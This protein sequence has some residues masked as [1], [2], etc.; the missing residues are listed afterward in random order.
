[1]EKAGRRKPQPQ[2]RR[3][4]LLQEALKG[5]DETALYTSHTPCNLYEK[6]EES[7]HGHN[8]GDGFKMQEGTAGEANKK[9]Q[10]LQSLHCS[11]SEVQTPN[12][13]DGCQQLVERC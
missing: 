3:Q 2:A 9:L 4:Q 10:E 12:R 8:P 11:V 1:M 5:A 7:R 6:V 13:L